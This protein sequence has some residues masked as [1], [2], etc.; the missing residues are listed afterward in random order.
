MLYINMQFLCWGKMEHS[1]SRRRVGDFPMLERIVAVGLLIFIQFDE[2]Q[3]GASHRGRR[4]IVH[5]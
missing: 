4:Y 5:V 2:R 1:H 3:R